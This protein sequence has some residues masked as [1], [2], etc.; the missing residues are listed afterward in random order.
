MDLPYR[1][2][3]VYPVFG[4]TEYSF[5]GNVDFPSNEEAK[6]ARDSKAK[7]LRQEYKG[8]SEVTIRRGQ[9]RNQLRPYVS[10]G[11]PDG[12]N[13]HVYSVTIVRKGR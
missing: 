4:G 2:M 3:N 10:L 13:G 8:N 1:G 6:K 5:W 7:A 11:I 9:L 12:R